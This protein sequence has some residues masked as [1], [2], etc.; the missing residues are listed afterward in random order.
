MGTLTTPRQQRQ[1]NAPQ[2]DQ[3]PAPG[4]GG[5]GGKTLVL[6]LLALATLLVATALTI[7]PTQA[8]T[9]G[10][11][12]N[13][14]LDVPS[15]CLYIAGQFQLTATVTDI[16]GTA[17]A[18]GT[19]VRWTTA[20]AG[21]VPVFIALVPATTTVNGQASANFLIVGSG[22]GFITAT[23][24]TARAIS[25]V[26]I[27]PS[28]AGGQ[29]G[30]PPDPAQI[31][32]LPSGLTE[33]R[34]TLR[35][36]VTDANGAPVP[37]GT[38]I[39]WQVSIVA[40][41]A[42]QLTAIS[43]EHVTSDGV[44]SAT[45]SVVPPGSITVE[46]IV[47]AGA[48]LRCDTYSSPTSPS[49][50]GPTIA[51][52]H[53]APPDWSLLQVGDTV[54]VTASVTDENGAAVPD[55]TTVTWQRYWLMA[56]GEFVS[57]AA[58][59][60][61][62]LQVVSQ[63]TVTTSGEASATFR[64]VDEAPS[65]SV[66]VGA[67]G[68]SRSV[69]LG[70]TSYPEPPG[71]LALS[72][73][74]PADSDGIV[75]TDSTLAVDAVL[76]YSG[77]GTTIYVS[78][79]VLRIAGTQEWE[80]GRSAL[81]VPGQTAQTL[82]LRRLFGFDICDGVSVDGQ[83]DW[84]CPVKLED[85]TIHIPAGTASGTFTIS[86]AI[87]VNG[88][89]YTDTLEVTVVA[90]GSIDEVAEV[91][92]DFAERERGPNRGEPYPANVPVGGATKFRLKAL[93]ENGAASAE[94]AIGS[95]L[96]TTTIGAL[97]AN[98][99]DGCVGGATTC[100]IPVSAITAANADKIDVTLTHADRANA[101][102]GQVR[103]TMITTD[104]ETFAP[105]PLTVTL[106]GAAASLAISE[107]RAALLN[108]ATESDDRDV[109]K[110]TVTAADAQGSNVDVPYRAPRAAITA[111][112]GRLITSGIRVVW[113]EDGDDRDDA[114]DQFTRSTSNVVEAT[115]SVTADAESPLDVGEYTIELRTAD[116]TAT[117]TFSVVGPPASVA[118]GEP[119]G[120]F[121]VNGT[122]TFTAAVHDAA[123]A[124]VPDG[125]PVS[126]SARSTTESTILVQLSADTAI[127][128]GAAS[129]TYLSVGAGTAIITAESGNVRDVRLTA[130]GGAS[131]AGSS[132]AGAA[133]PLPDP[134]ESLSNSGAGGY[135]AWLGE[136][137]T[138]A[139]ALLDGLPETESIQLWQN[140]RW[141]RYGRDGGR[142]VPG[143]IDFTIR[144]GDVLF[145]GP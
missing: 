72:L 9:P 27:A 87:T 110:L 76:T 77:R 13:V 93:N 69:A 52:Q 17:V 106:A 105:P 42:A 75:A 43:E 61:G 22:T 114:H 54:T 21:T 45:Y 136:Q 78:D 65:I 135:A 141:L 29:P 90:P 4:L 98:I 41:Q 91:Q 57:P 111:P 102:R 74:L 95:I 99:G 118:L 20:S 94:G 68:I 49:P 18:D 138:S 124:P 97:S 28:S 127:Q 55:G 86:G 145:L 81:T 19:E 84:T 30:Q 31:S 36:A 24:G 37:D 92:F 40:G 5:G 101:G 85:A 35:A 112:D 47:R 48:A 83:T 66:T 115:I 59:Y 121:E 89:E 63:D 39:S 79:G 104:G 33:G 71:D 96:I 100:S 53:N 128:D 108:S 117:R 12:A 134:S 80:S 7:K 132:A 62:V 82:F 23:A 46:A 60:V 130:I 1:R 123:G 73:R 11:P 143:S 25:Q 3:H 126:W 58:S 38:P 51:V 16:N 122:L 120:S 113:T 137:M 103:A 34:I 56:S 32:I 67:T 26:S 144:P 142:I 119:Q 125:T 8:Q 2:H 129:A 15:G 6:A 10:P 107:P 133:A 139:S 88:R 116:K 109:L 50:P 140:G 14:E 44:A 70:G 131:I 64:V